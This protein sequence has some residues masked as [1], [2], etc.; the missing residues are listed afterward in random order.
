M[1]DFDRIGEL[2]HKITIEHVTEVQ[3]ENGN[4]TNDWAI[5][6]ED[7]AQVTPL[8]GAEAFQARQ[9]DA[10][11]DHRVQLRYRPGVRPKMRVRFQEPSGIV[12][13][14]DIRSVNN[15]DYRGERLELMCMELEVA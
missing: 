2:R 6:L 8:A 14:F 1:P 15:P 3:D 7:W 10:S 9:L 13:Y 11:L 4:I 5:F 12:R